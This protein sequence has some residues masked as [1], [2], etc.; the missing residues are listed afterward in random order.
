[1]ATRWKKISD[2]IDGEVLVCWVALICFGVIAV[3]VLS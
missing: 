2:S 1:M 3:V